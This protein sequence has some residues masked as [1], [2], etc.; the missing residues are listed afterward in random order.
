MKPQSAKNKGRRLQQWVRDTLLKIF[1]QFTSDDIRST[2]M[3]A[4]G[5]DLLLSS[6]ARAAFPYSVECKNVE[7]VNIWKTWEQ[8]ESFCHPDCQPL[9]IIKRNNHKPLVVLDAEYFFKLHNKE[10]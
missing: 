10:T 7:R 1:P 5:E 9:V 3:G 4:S 8:A 2:S 6:A